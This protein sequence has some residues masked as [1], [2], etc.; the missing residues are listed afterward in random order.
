M[1]YITTISDDEFVVEI[2]DDRRI[3]LNGKEYVVD[4]D[5]LG[6]QPVFS[7]LVDGRSYEAYVYPGEDSMQVLMHGRFYPA[8]V[9]DERERRLKAATGSVITEGG[10]YHLKA[11]MPGLVVEIP[12]EQGQEVEKGDVLVILESMKMQNELRSPRPGV[13]SRVRVVP[14]DGVEQHQI[15]LSIE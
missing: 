1:K 4:F 14:N 9:E 13:V 12:V 2:L 15:L 10:E 3:E 7:L 11:P 5:E 8:T 6:D